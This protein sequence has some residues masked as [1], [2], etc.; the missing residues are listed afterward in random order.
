MVFALEGPP[1]EDARAL[2][3]ALMNVTHRLGFGRREWLRQMFMAS[4]TRRSAGS[5][6]SVSGIRR[7]PGASLVPTARPFI[8]AADFLR[9][10]VPGAQRLM[11]TLG[12]AGWRL[13]IDRTLVARLPHSRC[14]RNCPALLRRRKY[15]G[16]D[17]AMTLLFFAFLTEADHQ[18]LFAKAP[19]CT[20]SGRR[21]RA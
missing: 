7:R 15:R 2:V 5:V 16:E 4:P 8:Q 21:R 14:P 10:Y 9:P 19:A 20:L 13:A 11:Q 6:R 12:V 1:D 17:I 18:A 3:H